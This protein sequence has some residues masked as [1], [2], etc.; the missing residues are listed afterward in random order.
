MLQW[1]VTPMHQSSKPIVC[2]CYRYFETNLIMAIQR[3]V[4]NVH[5]N[6]IKKSYDSLSL[7][8]V[9]CFS[10]VKN[11]SQ[12]ISKSFTYIYHSRGHKH[13][14]LPSFLQLKSLMRTPLKRLHAV[15]VLYLWYKYILISLY[16]FGVNH[17]DLSFFFLYQ[18]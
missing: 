5:F 2:L 1:S 6:C 14:D 11:K 10:S 18:L 4:I 13:I 17:W 7:W 12:L 9:L 15:N 3:K 8:Q 16:A